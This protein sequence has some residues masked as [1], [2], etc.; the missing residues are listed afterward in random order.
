[1]SLPGDDFQPP[2][3]LRNR[4]L[5]SMLASTGARRGPIA[6]RSAPLVAAEK[7]ILLDCGDGV[8]L[9][10]LYSCPE[11]STGRLAVILHGWE[12]SATSLY[13]LSLGQQLFERGFEVV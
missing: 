12:G 7:A 11:Q 1:M 6:R 3:W 13:V 5:Q 8:R 10:C 9:Q 2:R 4:H